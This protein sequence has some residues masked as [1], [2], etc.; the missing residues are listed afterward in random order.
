MVCSTLHLK[1]LLLFWLLEVLC[2][3]Y[4]VFYHLL[5]MGLLFHP[6]DSIQA[7]DS[8]S[9]C[10]HDSAWHF[11]SLAQFLILKLY[12]ENVSEDYINTAS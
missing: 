9:L 7:V 8:H 5:L 4:G 2:A 1:C 12:S 6:A 10:V 3:A 11:H